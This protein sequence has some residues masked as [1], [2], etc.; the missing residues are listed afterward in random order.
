MGDGPKELVRFVVD[1]WA[2][3]AGLDRMAEQLAPGYVHHTPFGDFDFAGFRHGMAWVETQFAGRSY[4]VEQITVEDDL[5]AAYLSWSATRVSDGSA[6]DGRGAYFCRFADGLI[7][8]DW[9]V[10][11]PLS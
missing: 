1:C 5:A 2:D 6:V 8:E 11:A 9:D 3:E 10:F 4:R 7:A